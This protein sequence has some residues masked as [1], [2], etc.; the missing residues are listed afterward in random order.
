MMAPRFSPFSTTATTAAA[1]HFDYLVIGAGSGG[2]ASARRAADLHGA[3]VAVVERAPLGGTCVNVGCVPKKIMWSASEMN[4]NMRLAPDYGFD[5][6]GVQGSGQDAPA[7]I[8]FNWAKMKAARDAYILRLNG[9]YQQN[10]EGSGVEVFRGSARFTDRDG[11][12]TGA[13]GGT[14]QIDGGDDAGE[15]I[16]ANHVLIASGGYPILPDDVRGAAELG[17]TSDGFFE[18]TRQ[19]RKVAVVGAGYIAVELAGV[20][21]GLG[22]DVSLFVRGGTVLRSFDGMVSDAVAQGLEHAGVEL[23]RHANVESVD[24]QQQ[25]ELHKKSLKVNLA[26]NTGAKDFSGFDEVIFAVG[27]APAV[28]DIGLEHVPGV[29]VGPAGHIVNDPFSNTNA[30]CVYALGDVCGFWE[31]TPV[32]IAA[33]RRLA[34]RLFGGPVHAEAKLDY[35]CIPTVVFSHPPVGTIGMTEEEARAEYGDENIT[36]YTSTFVNLHYSLMDVAP[37]DKPRSCIKLVCEGPEERVRGLHVVGMA[38][39]ELLQG[40]GVAMKMGA[41]KADFDSSVAIHPTAAEEVV[42]LAPWGM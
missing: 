32:A 23:V 14:V 35:A 12:D 11:A 31:L 5:V 8:G 15:I 36:C 1:K 41:T 9:I 21:A 4:A 40:F 2:M 22:S 24:E 33:G 42:T 10:L 29:D 13:G 28:A 34:D 37:G 20:L 18:L 30:E 16:S 27:R 7:D 19:P 6:P 17:I 26:G 38:A 25:G 39:D 3:S